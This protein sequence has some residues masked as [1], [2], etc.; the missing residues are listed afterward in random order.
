MSVLRQALRNYLEL[1]R[2]LGFKLERHGALLPGFVA[3]VE[4]SGSSIITTAAALDWA[5][6][7]S[8]VTAKWA[9][10]RLAMVRAFAAY[11]QTLDPRTEVPAQELLSHPPRRKPPPYI[12]SDEEVEAIM[13]ATDRI[14]DPFRAHTYRTVVGL[15]AST[16]MRVGEAIAL[17]RSALDCTEGVITVRNG[18]FGKSR[19]VPLHPQA[20][21]ALAE[22][23]RH[24][25]RRFRR[26]ANP[27][28]FLSLA[29][30]RLIYSDVHQTFLHLLVAASLA[31]REPHRPRIHDL[32]H[33]FAVRTLVEW[34]RAGLDAES[35]L[36]L[37]STYLGHVNPSSTYWYLAAAPEL[38]G[39]A[40]ER[41]EENL[42]ELP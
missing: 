29:G 33:T 6:K 23:A 41:L 28:F 32:R 24:R 8:R 38:L 3:S 5:T 42:G 18:K 11:V 9:A 1:R 37:L 15:L 34:Y 13:D 21:S 2:A 10:A 14:T 19:S 22:Y 35:R 26:P 30:S 36:P 31:D 4:A 7:S 17:D 20:S 16:G 25:D 39:A 12:Y 40:A 27:A